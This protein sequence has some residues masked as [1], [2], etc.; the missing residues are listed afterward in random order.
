M[1]G[2]GEAASVIAVIDISAKI[3][4]L[5]QTYISAVKEAR[6][7]IQR[8]R[9][10]V[11]SLQD[12]LTD[13]KDLAED[14]SLSKRSVFSRLN[15]HNGPVQ[16]CK[17]DL[18][19]L[20][21]RLE[22]G[23]G[24]S[25]MRRFGLRAL[26]WPFSSK[27]I[28]KRL[29]VINDHKTTFTLALTSDHFA[30]TRTIKDDIA[31]M[32]TEQRTLAA[33][34]KQREIRHWL[35]SPD[36]SSNY[37][38]ARKARQATTGEWFLKSNE[39]EKWK[40]TSRSFLWL[41]GIPGCGKS[42]LCSTALEEVKSQYKSNPTVAIA[43]FY[44]DFNDSEKQRHDK[45]TH[46]LIEQLAWQSAKALAC[47]ES[48]FSRCQDG[49]QQPT[50]DAL[51]VAVQQMLNEFEETF[52]ILDALDECKEREELLLLLK[53][54]TSWG[55]GKLHVLATSRRERDIEETLESLTTSE[56]CLQSALVD[57]DIRTHLSERLQN[58]PKLKRWPANVRGEIKNTLM[59]G[60]QG[61]FRWVVCQLDVLRKCLKVDALRRALKTLPKTLNETYDRILRS[62]DEDYS[63][64]AFRILQWLVYS[65]RPLRMEE[66]VEVIAIDTEQ[67]QFNPENRLPDPRDLLTICSSLVTTI[68]VTTKGNDG[69]S[70]ETTELRLAHFSVKEY[71]ISDRIRTGTAFQYD[72]QS[73]GEE[74]IAQSCLTYLLQFQS[75]VLN[76]ENLNTFPLALY[77]AEHWCRHFRAMKDSDQATKLGMQLFQGDTF[78]SWIRLFNPEK[79][80]ERSDVDRDITN[81]ASPLYY[82]SHQG[83]FKLVILFLEK[84]ADV[85]AQG[86]EYGSALQAA[87]AKGYKT[88]AALLLEN[89]ADVNAQGGHYGNALQAASIKGHEAIAVL[90][91]EN[92]ANVNAQGGYYG[93]ALQ[94][95]SIGGYKAIAA[96]LLENKADVNSQGGR[97]GNALQAASVGGYKAIAAFLLENGADVNSQG[98]RYGNALQ[99]AS[100][101]GHETITALLLEKGA[102]TG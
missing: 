84:G 7:D 88:I 35:S 21:A 8:L 37:N 58:D 28:D 96:F 94:A 18:K 26:K 60:A 45:F 48:L 78:M 4:E 74:E 66:M 91:L 76:S 90:L 73:R 79:P 19:Q 47:L 77:A 15:Q 64:D 83:L 92:G 81:V 55:A 10:R 42:I 20:V 52:I 39:F 40:M 54:L 12:A 11:T 61:M 99:A 100:V 46:S 44:F 27:D 75:G 9:D 30:F 33:S 86:G 16:Q 23:K 95:A 89:G 43:Y 6:K 25:E 41:Y 59:E 56:I 2:L 80:W 87:S 68:S 3:F 49:K 57:H 70:N 53:N 63:Q 31:T 65:A 72:I 34:E 17:G 13:V 69:A 85:N 38:A 97:Y 98:G 50:Q 36:P 67:S 29:Q 71:L 102:R 93:N 32:Q 22:L 62:I 5:C 24:E 14:L 1:S 82:A 51:E 101:G